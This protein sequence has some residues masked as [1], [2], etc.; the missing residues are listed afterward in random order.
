MSKGRYFVNEECQNVISAL[1]E[2]VWDSKSIED[3]RL[4]DGNMNVDSLDALEYSTEEYMKDILEAINFDNP[5][6]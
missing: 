3:K 5:I 2:A 6:S 4:D 1:S